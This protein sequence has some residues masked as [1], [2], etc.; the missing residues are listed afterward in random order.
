MK[1]FSLSRRFDAPH[2]PDKAPHEA[3]QVG[4][5]FTDELRLQPLDDESVHHFFKDF[6]YLFRSIFHPDIS[7]S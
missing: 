2:C 7:Q 4:I 1:N 6:G 5:V 3:Y